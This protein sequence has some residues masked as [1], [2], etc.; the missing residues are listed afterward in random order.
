MKTYFFFLIPIFFAFGCAGT[1]SVLGMP[2][3]VSDT[4]FDLAP[5]ITNSDEVRNAMREEYPPLLRDAGIRGAV[6]LLVFVDEMGQIQRT[7]LEQS[8][9]H[10]AL[11]DMALELAKI[12]QFNPAQNG[13]K[14]VPVLVRVP[15]NL[16][17]PAARA[18]TKRVGYLN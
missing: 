5:E 3:V 2:T 18:A 12:I 6:V 14:A 13:G 16:V 11:D 10:Q 8:S 1:L 15:I 9:G 7:S 17:P 4:A